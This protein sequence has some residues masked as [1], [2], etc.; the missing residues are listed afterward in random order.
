MEPCGGGTACR[1]AV[2][3]GNGSEPV[4]VI[5]GRVVIVMT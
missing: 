5:D 1:S 2:F 4:G 3:S